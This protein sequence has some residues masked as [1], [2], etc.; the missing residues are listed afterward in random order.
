MNAYQ[1]FIAYSSADAATAK[2]ACAALEDS[3]IRCWIGPRDIMA[4]Q[5][6]GASIINAIDLCRVMVVIFSSSSNKS[7]QVRREIERAVAKGV[8]ILPVRIDE[9]LPDGPIA[10]FLGSVHWLDTRTLILEEH[11]PRLIETV[12]ALLSGAQADPKLEKA[13]TV[14]SNPP[15][16]AGVT[17]PDPV[18]PQISPS[19]LDQRQLNPSRQSPEYWI[20]RVAK[21][22]SLRPADQPL[23][24]ISFSSQDQKWVDDLRA[25]LDPRLE[26]LQDTDGQPYQLWN[27]SDAK[28]GTSPGDEFPEI[29]A[30]KM[31]RCRAALLVLSSSYFKSNYCRSIELPF[32]MWRREN[33]KLMCLPLKLGTLPIDRVKLPTYDGTPRHVVISELIDDRQ[34]APNFAT[35]RHRDLNLKQLREDGFESEIENRFEG[36]ARRVADY[37]KQSFAANEV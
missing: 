9:T 11:L 3:G 33:H 13:A 32:L 28:R 27:F 31:W 25:F 21:E 7:V 23:I 37:L 1:V 12:R 4:G 34:A 20:N 10:Y 29:V 15:P 19:P 14:P 2:A 6:Y 17:D 36:I 35:S 18:P 16:N 30:E 22:R 24:L 26:F 5:E 8:P